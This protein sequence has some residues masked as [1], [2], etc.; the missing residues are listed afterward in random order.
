MT[1]EGKLVAYLKKRVKTFGGSTRKCEWSNHAGAPDQLVLLPGK[2][3]WVE[4]KQAGQ[5]P[6]PIQL[7]EHQIMREA[8]C[9]VYVVDSKEGIDNLFK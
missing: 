9:E 2:H 1:P 7:R 8:G 6:R 3:F 4:L 5:K